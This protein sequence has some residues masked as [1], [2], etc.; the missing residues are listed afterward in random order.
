MSW[1]KLSNYAT[2]VHNEEGMY[3][4][5]YHSTC[6]VSWNDQKIILNTGGW[7]SATTKKKMNQSSNQFNLEF[8]VYQEKFDWYIDYRGQRIPFNQNTITLQR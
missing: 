4:V 6:I 7:F 2:T 3:K 5:I 1:N 8:M